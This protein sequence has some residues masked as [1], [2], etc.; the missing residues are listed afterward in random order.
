[1]GAGHCSSSSSS[2]LF[3]NTHTNTH[4]YTHKYTYKYTNKCTNKFTYKHT[5]F[6]SEWEEELHMG[7]G[8]YSTLNFPSW[9]HHHHHSFS[10]THRQIAVQIHMQI[11]I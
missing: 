7:A 9:H 2:K 10:L 3:L 11:H 6:K 8:H 1:M 5:S 4:K